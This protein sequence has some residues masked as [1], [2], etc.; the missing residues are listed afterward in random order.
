MGLRNTCGQLN[1]NVNCVAAKDLLWSQHYSVYLNVT[2]FYLVVQK[3]ILVEI[4]DNKSISEYS[5]QAAS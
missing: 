1:M 5:Y 2:W 3:Y 4:D